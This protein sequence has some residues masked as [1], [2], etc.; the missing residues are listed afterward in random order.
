MAPAHPWWRGTW[1][2]STAAPFPSRRAMDNNLRRP[3]SVRESTW[4]M[5]RRCT[6]NILFMYLYHTY[7]EIVCFSTHEAF[8][9][10]VFHLLVTT[11]PLRRARTHHTS[12]DASTTPAECLARTFLLS[13]A[14]QQVFVSRWRFRATK[15]HI[16]STLRR[17]D[18]LCTRQL[19]VPLE[20]LR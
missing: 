4:C 1:S 14:R 10:P 3:T 5:F 7:G 17:D 6:L 12:V 20:P 13:L 19:R 16:P 8:F 11:A 2:R 18:Y 15:L 9:F